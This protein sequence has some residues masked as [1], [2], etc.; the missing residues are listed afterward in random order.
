MIRLAALRSSV[1]L[2]RRRGLVNQVRADT[3][4]AWS[5]VLWVSA[6]PLGPCPG[7]VS[8]ALHPFLLNH[9]PPRPPTSPQE[10]SASRPAQ[11]PWRA[12]SNNTL[13]PCHRNRLNLLYPC[14]KATE[15]ETFRLKAVTLQSRLSTVEENPQP[16]FE[17]HPRNAS[18]HPLSRL[19]PPKPLAVPRPPPSPRSV[20]LFALGLQSATDRPCLVTS[21]AA[22]EESP[23]K[24]A[25]RLCKV[26]PRCMSS[27]GRPR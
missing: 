2:E 14:P 8:L 17:A 25:V 7:Q 6:I 12:Q 4:P 10:S 11:R 1:Q 22:I 5:S 20:P 15:T 3:V 21:L 16:P 19:L 27:R 23:T 9:P 13:Q 24:M 26:K 18:H